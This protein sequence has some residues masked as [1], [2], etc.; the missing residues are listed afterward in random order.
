MADVPRGSAC[1]DADMDPLHVPDSLEVPDFL[2]VLETVPVEASPALPTGTVTLLMTDIEGS[3]RLWEASE[4][5]AA[6]AIA[7]HYQLLRRRGRAPR[8]DPAGRAGRGRQ[9]GR[10]L[11]QGL[12]RARRRA[13]RATRVRATRRGRPAGRCACASRSTPARRSCATRG[14][15]SGRRSFAARA[16]AVDRSRR[17]DIAL[18]RHSRPGGRRGS[19]RGRVAR[20]RFAPAEGPRARRAGMAAVSPRSRRRHSRRLR[21]LEAVPNNLPVQLT[22]FVGREEELADVRAAMER[23]RLVTLTGT[24][25]CGKTRLALQRPPTVAELKPDGVWW[26]E[27]APVARPELV[28]LCDRDDDRTAARSPA[29]RS[30]TRSRSSCVTSTSS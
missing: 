17:P 5:D 30:S 10:R 22:T 27:L 15:T 23:S 21:S 14:T 7:R 3:T 8:R 28:A 4:D 6:V 12:R 19:R 24:G 18:R 25:G 1:D 16:S 11:L 13:R 2:D 20:S 29:D 9:R 26:I